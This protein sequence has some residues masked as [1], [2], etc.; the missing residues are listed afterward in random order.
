MNRGIKSI[1]LGVFFGTIFVLGL[2]GNVQAQEECSVATLQGDYLM[3]GTTLDS[4]VGREVII[5]IFTFD[6]EGT[7]TTRGTRSREGVIID[8][9]L[10]ASYELDSDCDGTV[11]LIP[12]GAT[13][14]MVVTRDRSEGAL[15]RTNDGWMATRYIKKR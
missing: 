3:T 1:I 9:T 11:T 6:G 5:S 13:W 15:I 10:T 7:L 14:R 2:V 4:P 8:M 12:S